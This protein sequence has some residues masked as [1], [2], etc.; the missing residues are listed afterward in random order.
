MDQEFVVAASLNGDVRRQ[1]V[2]TPF[3]RIPCPHAFTQALQDAAHSIAPNVAEH[4]TILEAISIFLMLGFVDGEPGESK[5]TFRNGHTICTRDIKC[6]Q[7][8][9]VRQ[10][11]CVDGRPPAMIDTIEYPA[12]M[13]IYWRIFVVDT[14]FR[15]RDMGAL[16]REFSEQASAS[17]YA[18]ALAVALGGGEAVVQWH[19]ATEAIEG[20]R[21]LQQQMALDPEYR[22][23]VLQAFKDCG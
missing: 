18:D 16:A 10:M 9:T 13:W 6:P 19:S 14:P 5:Y 11:L 17:R 1:C 8:V 12:H 7:V 20:E 3:P 15:R 23:Q 4:V 22:S 2:A 21:A